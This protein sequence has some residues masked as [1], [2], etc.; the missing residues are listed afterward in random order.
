MS[1]QDDSCYE[2]LKIN[3]SKR[4]QPNSRIYLTCANRMISLQL[5]GNIL[6]R[7]SV[8][9]GK[10]ECVPPAGNREVPWEELSHR[11]SGV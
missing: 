10:A 1:H 7:P 5:D 6:G 8:N 2:N 9:A 4:Q 3:G 11:A